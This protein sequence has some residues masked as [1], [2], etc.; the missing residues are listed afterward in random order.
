MSCRKK[1]IRDGTNQFERLLEA[2][3]PENI[4]IDGRNHADILRIIR[5]VA[6]DINFFNFENQLQGNW[7]NYFP[8]EIPV[9][10]EASGTNIAE[11]S[12]ALLLAFLQLSDYLKDDLNALTRKHLYYYYRDILNFYRRT[13]V[14]ESVHVLF[15]PGKNVT[16]Y[17]INKGTLLSGGKDENGNE[18]LYATDQD[19]VI[20]PAK[21]AGLKSVFIDADERVYAAKQANVIPEA[22]LKAGGEPKWSA[23]GSSQIGLSQDQQTMEKAEIGFAIASPQLWLTD[24][25]REIEFVFTCSKRETDINPD[26]NLIQDIDVLLSAEKEWYRPQVNKILAIT[27]N[28]V[29]IQLTVQVSVSST[30]PPIIALSETKMAGDFTT[31]LPV[32][33]F[34][35]KHQS[36]RYK[37]VQLR[38]LQFVSLDISI[39]VNGKKQLVVLNDNGVLDASKPFFPFGV[40]PDRRSSLFIGSSELFSKNVSEVQISYQWENLPGEDFDDYYDEYNIP[41]TINNQLF[42]AEVYVLYKHDWIEIENSEFDLFNESNS[43]PSV[44]QTFSEFK[45][46]E[47][48]QAFERINGLEVTEK[49]GPE[50][51]YGFLRIQFTGAK[52]VYDNL[53]SKLRAFGHHEYSNLYSEVAIKKA[54]NDSSAGNFPNK[55]Y[56]PVMSNLS[57]GYQSTQSVILSDASVPE[58]FFHVEPFG[59][60]EKKLS[61]AFTL[62]PQFWNEGNFYLGLSGIEAPL[63]ISLL[64]QVA[65][66]TAKASPES[67]PAEI[68]W[69]L[70]K[71]EGWELF[72]SLSILNDTT[73]EL[74]KSGILT[75]EIG[76]EAILSDF[77]FEEKAYWIRGTISQFSEGV[78]QLI[79]IFPNA[80]STSY[81]FPETDENNTG[82]ES[83]RFIPAET[84]NKLDA[85]DAKIKKVTQPFPSFGGKSSETDENYLARVSERLRHKHRAVNVW[86]YERI[87]L[88][89]FPSI[90]KVK[91]LEHASVSDDYAPGS[92]TLLVISNLR[93]KETG[94]P[95]EP[96]TGFDTLTEIKLYLKNY[97]SPFVEIN[98]VNPTYEQ[99]LVDCKVAFHTGFDSGYYLNQLN[100]D[101]KHYLSPWAYEEGK[102]IVFGGKIYRSDI[103]QF[104]ENQIYVDYVTDFKLYHI[105]EGPTVGGIGCMV[106]ED[107]F[108]V[109]D[110]QGLGLGE[111]TIEKDFVVGYESEVAIGNTPRSIL[112]SATDHRIELI[113][114]FS[115]CKGGVFGGIGFMAIE[116]DFIIE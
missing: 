99:L 37:Y 112:V 113:E 4:Q 45:S 14:A 77:Q 46:E 32:A 80:V 16:S 87:V 95:L 88:E 90:Y 34:V 60:T 55:P 57:I 61:G 97:V 94:N 100:E 36:S 93:Y 52:S 70:L 20:Y 110:F 27:L 7:D 24:G 59:F 18:R 1:Y 78:C 63:N 31:S 54:L 29:E 86:D 105:Y 67:P 75:F 17:L 101:I 3:L 40:Q 48:G 51:A 76:T 30:G 5:G 83:T 109:D 115:V 47:T 21:I 72:D 92:V 103:L 98:V 58:Q 74:Q 73:Q 44:N 8:E 71:E 33:K 114:D 102:D 53:L 49:I 107:D 79:D 42:K 68:E 25:T 10:E 104:V 50:T 28:P 82:I 81:I 69:S 39:V 85:K 26:I 64:F 106:I 43:D 116:I 91:C 15:E 108:I 111:M 13:P 38:S 2:L 6:A 96:K 65:E 35:L 41:E 22:L 19:I 66:G 89:Q 11:P 9:L 56:T 84:I 12:F 62:L 23:F